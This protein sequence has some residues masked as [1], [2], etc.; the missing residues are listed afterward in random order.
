MTMNVGII[1]AGLSGLT[2]ATQLTAAGYAVD[3]FD[4]GRAVG[5]RMSSRRI[6]AG[7]WDH[8][9][10]YFTIRDPAF[11][12]FLSTYLPEECLVP[13]SGAFGHWEGDR[14]QPD[15]GDEVRYVAQPSMSA[16]CKQL[17]TRLSQH[18]PIHTG[19]QI[20]Q[21]RSHDATLLGQ[22][23]WQLQDQQ[24]NL[25]GPFDW[26]ISTAPP[27]QTV[28][29]LEPHT[30]IAQAIGEVEMWPC[31][32]WMATT[33]D[34]VAAWV[35]Q[36]FG[37]PWVGIKFTHPSLGWVALNHTKPQRNDADSPTQSLIVQA[38]WP[39]SAAMVEADA[40]AIAHTLRSAFEQWLGTALTH[41]TDQSIHRWRYAAPKTV[42]PTPY[43]LDRDRGLA[44]CGDWCV[45][46]R[47][48]GAFLSGLALSHAM[49][50]T[51]SSSVES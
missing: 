18:A 22:P 23:Q 45:A 17:A 50:S 49:P 42:A 28:A 15:G 2:V 8:G 46:G 51:A 4:K 13:W 40:A 44:A 5:G 10:Q 19:V 6:T 11:R 21:L 47:V 38:N 24:G 16:L 30:A 12:A 39:W 27:V 32:T 35:E 41:L 9:A 3:V 31:W 43:L 48:E 34:P 29:L 37:Q 26:V 36:R 1:G 14:I 7:Y 25:Y 20:V 33:R